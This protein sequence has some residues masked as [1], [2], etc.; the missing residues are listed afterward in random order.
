MPQYTSPRANAIGALLGVALALAVE[1][2][3]PFAAKPDAG[4]R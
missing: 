1:A 3:P 2:R 4:R